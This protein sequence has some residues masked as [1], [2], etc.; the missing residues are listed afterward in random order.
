MR[1]AAALGALV[2]LVPLATEARDDGRYA[3]SPLKSWFDK[4]ASKNGLC[5]SFAD[6]IRLEDV[7]WETKDG[8]Y[9][10]YLDDHWIEVPD[11]ALV[12][13]PNRAGVAIVWPLMFNGKTY[14][15][16][17]FMPGSGT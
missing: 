14:A 10:V 9:R 16:R 6:G 3:N 17:C 2:L 15:I 13:V 7:Q 5:C 11:N 12:L 4:L 1:T 8:H